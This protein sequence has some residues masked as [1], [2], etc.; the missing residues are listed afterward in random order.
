[1]PFEVTPVYYKLA[2]YDQAQSAAG[3]D[4]SPQQQQPAQPN[5][6]SAQPAA[7]PQQ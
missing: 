5:Q 6:A 1:M 4:P 3:A 7:P 2:R